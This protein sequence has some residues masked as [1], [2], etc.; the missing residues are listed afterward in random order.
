MDKIEKTTSL[1][2]KKQ[3]KKKELNRF[4]SHSQKNNIF[5]EISFLKKNI[6]ELSP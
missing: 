2:W 5:G 3:N 6:P 4:L 1:D